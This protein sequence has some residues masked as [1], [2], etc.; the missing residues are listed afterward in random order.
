MPGRMHRHVARLAL[1][2]ACASLAARAQGTLPPVPKDLSSLI[3]VV[4]DSIR[5]GRLVG[6]VVTVVGTERRGVTDPQGIF[7]IDSVPPGSHE[8]VVT[9]PL[10]DTLG[11]EIHSAPFMLAAG[12]RQQVGA[13]TPTFEEVRAKACTRG[14][15][16]SGSAIIVGR[17][18]QADTQEPAAGASVSLVFKDKTQKDA[19]EKVRTGRVG[20]SGAFAICGLPS[21]ITGNLQATF[22]GVTTA[23]L[24]VTTN[25]E[26]LAT[27]IL[28]VG[29]NGPG[30]AM[31]SGTVKARGGG[32]IAGAQ[33]TVV[34]TT[35][36]VETSAGGAF[37]LAG[38]PSGTQEAVVRKLG[39][40]KVSQIVHLA[41][42]APATLQVE[43]EP[44][45]VL[46]TV[47]VVGQMETGLNKIG[48]M[49]R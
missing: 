8:I 6:A 41:A 38:L 32:P 26:S 43:L 45:T 18:L 27:A 1:L 17:V 36:I 39:F 30:K 42:A 12:Q 10:L 11:L 48:F 47:R 13:R 25:D 29:G 3:G 23:D 49:S 20:P 7:Q 21:T 46:G 28:A 16:A 33:V 19:V 40:A 34:G 2:L 22:A 44:A 5:G 37:T 9:H 15:V 31:L 24:P 35:T 14:G 4:D